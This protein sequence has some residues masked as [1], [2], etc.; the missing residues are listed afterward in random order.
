MQ[1]DLQNSYRIAIMFPSFFYLASFDA[2]LESGK[3]HK[4]EILMMTRRKTEII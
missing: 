4:E 3:L 2:L 1:I